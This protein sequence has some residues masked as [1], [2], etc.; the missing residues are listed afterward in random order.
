M[1]KVRRRAHIRR[2]KSGKSAQVRQHELTVKTDKTEVDKQVYLKKA[3]EDHWLLVLAEIKK[4]GGKDIL[5]NCHVNMDDL[6]RRYDS[7]LGWLEERGYYV[8]LYPNLSA[9]LDS[10]E[11]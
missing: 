3:R 10:P 8:S 1:A 9:L 2:T 7:L 11:R 6:R 5:V 4:H